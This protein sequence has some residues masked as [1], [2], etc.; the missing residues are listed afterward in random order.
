[1]SLPTSDSPFQRIARLFSG[2]EL[3]ILVALVRAEFKG[4]DQ[5]SALGAIWSAA[6]PLVALVVLYVVFHR[7]F[8]EDIP[9]YPLYLLL[10]IVLVGFFRST[11]SDLM[12]LFSH[13][14]SLLMNTTVPPLTVLLA[15]AS[16]NI[17]KLLGQLLI[18]TALS[19]FY[20]LL[21]VRA[22]LLLPLLVGFVALT[23][24]V[25]MLLCTIRVFFKDTG[26][27]WRLGSRLL[28]FATPVFYTLDSMSPQTR[29]LLF[30]LNPLTPF[31]I[32]FREG[33]MHLGQASWETFLYSI[34]IGL[35]A[36]AIGYW[37]F[38]LRERQAVEMA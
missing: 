32:G 6:S 26:H 8:G 30:W 15:A 20:G 18:C 16:T 4:S 35:V 1:M 3:E 25:A 33:L 13:Q 14:R 11:T 27:L 28:F 17:S 12:T 29:P 9:A 36:L 10:G 23:L 19:G 24:G 37:A 22:L 31:L 5:G 38:L 2:A 21:T 7:H 34:V